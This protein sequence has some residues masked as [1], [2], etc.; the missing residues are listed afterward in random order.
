MRLA[1]KVIKVMKIFVKRIAA[2]RK[3]IAGLWDI[4]VI[5][6]EDTVRCLEFESGIFFVGTLSSHVAQNS[7]RVHI[8]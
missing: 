2:V 8:K 3:G 6:G 7:S 5:A 1:E 4:T